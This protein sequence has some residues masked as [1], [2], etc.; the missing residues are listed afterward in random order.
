MLDRSAL[1]D[2]GSS[3]GEGPRKNLDGGPHAAAGWPSEAHGSCY[4]EGYTGSYGF[5][6]RSEPCQSWRFLGGRS[7]RR[8]VMMRF[9]WWVLGILGRGLEP[10]ERDLVLGDIAESGE[11]IA[12]AMRDLLGLIV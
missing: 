4:R 12:A 11:C 8:A 10:V 6:Q 1:H 5:L 9:G 7:R 2:L 3:G